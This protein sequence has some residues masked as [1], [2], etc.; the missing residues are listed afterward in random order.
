MWEVEVEQTK[1]HGDEDFKRVAKEW[2]RR[3]AHEFQ[4]NA[5]HCDHGCS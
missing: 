3:S 2:Q 1:V 4:E 5:H